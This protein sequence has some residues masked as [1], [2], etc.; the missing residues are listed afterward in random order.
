MAIQKVKIMFNVSS[1]LT[2]LTV[3]LYGDSDG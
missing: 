2:K 3:L 1:H